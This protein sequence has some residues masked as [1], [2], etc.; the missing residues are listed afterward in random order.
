MD[1]ILGIKTDPALLKQLAN[2]AGKPL[3]AEESEAQRISFV[4]SAV[5]GS[6]ISRTQIKTILELHQ[7]D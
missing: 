1:S 2:V 3:S 7:G 5:G 6:R 4:F